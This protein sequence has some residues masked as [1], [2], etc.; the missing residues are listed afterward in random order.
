[1]GRTNEIELFVNNKRSKGL[2]DSGSQISTVSEKFLKQNLPDIKI[3]EIETFLNIEVAGGHSLE[4]SGVVVLGFSFPSLGLESLEPVPIL[5][6]KERNY[7]KQVPFI[8][9]TN[10]LTHCQEKIKNLREVSI[11]LFIYLK[12]LYPG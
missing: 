9:G 6:V 5:V 4:N 1:M 7:N 8:I 12:Y 10:I 2:L 11:Y 3:E